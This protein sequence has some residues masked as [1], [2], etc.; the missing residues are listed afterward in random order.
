M[1]RFKNVI[2][3]L[4]IL[5]VALTVACAQQ[6]A[7]ADPVLMTD[8]SGQEFAVPVKIEKI[9]SLAPAITDI[10][11]A[12]GE[13]GKVVAADTYSVSVEG[14]DPSICVLEIY[15][16][17]AE[18]ILSYEPDL[19]L[20]S[21]LSQVGDEDPYKA[22]KEAGISVAYIPSSESI[23]GIYGDISFYGEL[24]GKDAEA[25]AL[26]DG[27]KAQID[28]IAAIGSTITDKKTVL[29]E[30]S[31]SPFIYSFGSGTFLNEMIEIIG[32]KNV[33]DS[34]AG[35]LAVADE[36]A[37]AANPDVILT[38]VNY[39]EDPVGEI[40]SRPAFADVTAVKNGDVYQIDANHSS[41]PSHNIVKA[42]KAMA[43]AIYPDS[44]VD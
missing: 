19:V 33:L 42:L 34:E 30:V 3:A 11:F 41:Q 36:T 7:N 10:A 5:A 9:V 17:N 8:P 35:W 13:G 16:P 21:G 31:A 2:A 1:K 20:V 15:P 6:P 23:E 26:A 39:I 38:N 24:L 40:L 27:M 44:Y 18:A 12:L 25:K 4:L 29:F 22:L 32:A 37:V 28:S 14:I 43:K